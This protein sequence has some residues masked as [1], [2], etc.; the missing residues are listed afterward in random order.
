MKVS[1]NIAENI[2]FCSHLENQLGWIVLQI[3]KTDI[4]SKLYSTAIYLQQSLLENS[5]L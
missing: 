3:F 4:Y 5:Y 2:F 1:I